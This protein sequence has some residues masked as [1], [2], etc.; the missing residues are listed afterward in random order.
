VGAIA[1][2]EMNTAVP[3]IYHRT[4][5]QVR[6]PTRFYLLTAARGAMP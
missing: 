5:A 1:P 4:P 2:D 6:V 3:P